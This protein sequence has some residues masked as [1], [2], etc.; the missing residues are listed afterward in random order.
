MG[1]GVRSWGFEGKRS[2]F[3]RWSFAFLPVPF[4]AELLTRNSEPR[5]PN[6]EPSTQIHCRG[7]HNCIAHAVD[8]LFVG[9]GDRS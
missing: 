2:G 6:S 8:D 3:H 9:R 7:N 4:W 1:F 5:T